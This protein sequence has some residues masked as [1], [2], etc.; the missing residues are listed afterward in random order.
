MQKIIIWEQTKAEKL[1][2][3]NKLCFKREFL[4]SVLPLLICY[5]L[6]IDIIDILDWSPTQVLP[7][8]IPHDQSISVPFLKDKHQQGD[9][10]IS[11]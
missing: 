9:I 6:E 3:K 1:Q 2:N 7:I 10:N 11:H 4:K 8:P 5:G